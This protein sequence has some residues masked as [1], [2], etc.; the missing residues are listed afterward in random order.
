MKE[1]WCFVLKISRFLCFCKMH[2]SQNLW[3]HRKHCEIMEITL[4][5][6]YFFWILNTIKMKFGQIL[7]CYMT[8]I[9]NMFWLNA[10]DWKLVPGPFMI[11]LKWQYSEIWSFLIVDIWHFEMSCIHLFKKMKHWNHYIIGYGVI[12][13]GC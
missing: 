1:K 4:I 13:A 2:C 5:Y 9:S 11:L 6:A 3:H 10:G 12:G 8:N 7:V